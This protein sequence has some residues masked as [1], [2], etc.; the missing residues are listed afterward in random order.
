MSYLLWSLIGCSLI[1]YLIVG[2]YITAKYFWCFGTSQVGAKGWIKVFNM[3][4]PILMVVL[5]PLFFVWLFVMFLVQYV[6]YKLKKK[7]KKE[8]FYTCIGKGG[9]YKCYGETIG[10]GTSKG[11]S[12]VIYQDVETKQ[13]H[14]RTRVDFDKRMKLLSK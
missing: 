3:V 1:A 8:H 11:T 6:Q 2:L 14:H 5:W 4:G 7:K 10:A 13:L 9:R 12:V